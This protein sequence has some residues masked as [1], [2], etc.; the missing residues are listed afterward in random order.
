MVPLTSLLLP[1]LL[2]AVAVFLVSAVIHMALGYHA[3]DFGRVPD[4]DAVRNALRTI[5][6]GDYAVP[7]AGSMQALKSPEFIEKV[8][9][10]PIVTM[11]VQP[12]REMSMA[13]ELTLWFVYLLVV[14][15]LAAYVAGRALEPGAE[16]LQVFRFAGTTAL[17]AYAL[18]SWPDTIWYKRS[19]TTSMKNTFDGIIYALVTAGVFGWLWPS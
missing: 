5:P 7:Y 9:A 10:G 19:A 6:G 17:V 3:G 8:K 15:S 13:R 11:T 4:E 2:S 12:G 18:S 14:S 16:Y 1:I